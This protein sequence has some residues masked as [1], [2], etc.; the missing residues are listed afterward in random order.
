MIVV[1]KENGSHNPNEEMEINDFLDACP[2]T[3]DRLPG[4]TC[5]TYNGPAPRHS[6]RREFNRCSRR[7]RKKR[8]T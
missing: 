3:K 4:S 1:R 6:G 5:I 2:V 8:P 7:L